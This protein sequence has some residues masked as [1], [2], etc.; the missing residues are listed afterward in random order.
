MTFVCLIIGLKAPAVAAGQGSY[1]NLISVVYPMQISTRR[2]PSQ[3]A[4]PLLICPQTDLDFFGNVTTN[5]ANEYF[6][7]R[8]QSNHIVERF[9]ATASPF[10]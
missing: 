8:H 2:F 9:S 10:T 4:P 1:H 5:N 7:R 3:P 6:T